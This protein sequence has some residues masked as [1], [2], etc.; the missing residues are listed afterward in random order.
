MYSMDWPC[1]VPEF[2]KRRELERLE[3]GGD[4]P[5]KQDYSIRYVVSCC[6]EVI[7]R[8]EDGK[9]VEYTERRFLNSLQDLERGIEQYRQDCREASEYDKRHKRQ[10]NRVQSEYEQKQYRKHLRQDAAALKRELEAAVDGCEGCGRSKALGALHM[11]HKLPVSEGGDNRRDNLIFLCPN[12]HA[13]AHAKMRLS[14]PSA[15][16]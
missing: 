8:W 6:K 13:D 2:D 10:R 12:C 5:A 14:A 4:P 3:A 11:H 16:R 7:T 15:A 9:E 1:H